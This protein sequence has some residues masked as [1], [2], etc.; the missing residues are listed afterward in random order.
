MQAREA[1]E[2]TI[3]GDPLAPVLDGQGGKPGIL[4]EIARGSRPPAQIDKDGPVTWPGLNELAM[5]LF[6][7]IGAE[8]QCF[9]AFA[10]LLENTAVGGDAHQRA[11]H[12]G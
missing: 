7:E 5:L 8:L 3:S 10:R 6:E 12:L 1:S 2:I 4:N 11:E 9:L